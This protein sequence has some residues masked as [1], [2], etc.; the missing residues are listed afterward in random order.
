MN[1]RTPD[2]HTVLD[3][4]T[5]ANRAPSVAEC[6]AVRQGEDVTVAE[7]L[8][9]E[10]EGVRRVEVHGGAG[11][12]SQES[13]TGE[14]VGVQVRVEDLGDPPAV[15]GGDALVDGHIDGRVDDEGGV[16]GTDDVG[17][18]AL[19]AAADLHDR[20]VAGG[21]LDG[22]VQL[23]PRAHAAGQLRD[24][25]AGVDEEHRGLGG[26]GTCGAVDDELAVSREL[27]EA[28]G[29]VGERDVHRSRDAPRIV[30]VRVADVE[31]ER[32]VVSVE[33]L[34]Q[35]LGGDLSEHLVLLRLHR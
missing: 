26:S 33:A 14:V 5:L 12:A 17:E 31:H 29:Q 7:R 25:V 24:R 20:R 1:E 10:V 3:A 9:V 16:A 27:P 28:L 6:G 4:I 2:T 11:A 34:C 15:R 8:E 19:R 18:A 21:D 32:A 35:L 30:L 13:G 23:G 22:V